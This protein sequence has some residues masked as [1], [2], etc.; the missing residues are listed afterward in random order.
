M[1]NKGYAR[2]VLLGSS[3]KGGHRA[4]AI[5]CAFEENLFNSKEA[6][7]ARACYEAIYG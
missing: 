2:S 4:Y 1:I 7:L 3:G 6:G 5:I